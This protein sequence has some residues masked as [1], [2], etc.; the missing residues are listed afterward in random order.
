MPTSDISDYLARAHPDLRAAALNLREEFYAVAIS[1]SYYAMFYAASAALASLGVAR[2]KHSAII[3]AFGQQLVK[4]GHIESEW[5][6]LLSEGFESRQ[7]NVYES[8][9][10]ADHATATSLLDGAQRFVERVETFLR[11]QGKL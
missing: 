6:R 11:Q 1:C 10:S 8:L 3:A 2:S 5:G 4:P 9:L 7:E